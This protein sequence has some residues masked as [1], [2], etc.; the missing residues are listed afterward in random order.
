MSATEGAIA[1]HFKS[2]KAHLMSGTVSYVTLKTLLG[3]EAPSLKSTALQEN[4]DKQSVQVKNM[5][6]GSDRCCFKMKYCHI[7]V[8]KHEEE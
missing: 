5:S 4:F 6:L 8:L 7:I 2:L 1:I 3:S